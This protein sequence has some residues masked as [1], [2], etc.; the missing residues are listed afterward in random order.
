MI[1]IAGMHRSGTSMLAGLLYK[2]GADFGRP[3]D[4]Y[5]ADI[6]NPD[7]YFEQQDIQKLNM[8]LIHGPWGKLSYLNLPTP[9]TVLSRGRRLDEALTEVSKRIENQVVKENRFC[10]TLPA[11]QQAGLKVD[12]V[13]IC[14]RNPWD[15]VRSLKKRNRLPFVIG[16]RLWHEHLIRILVASEGIDRR[17]F[18]YENVIAE[19]TNTKEFTDILNFMDIRLDEQKADLLLKD[20]LRKPERTTVQD[21]Q[22]PGYVE[23]L[24]NQLLEEYKKQ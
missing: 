13:I 1:L 23:K 17:L 5:P 19:A 22:L 7:G 15:V 16:F 2:S 9:Q 11:W 14:L 21:E 24:W 12:K 20:Y 4:F 6:W 10:I 3:E 8:K 18:L